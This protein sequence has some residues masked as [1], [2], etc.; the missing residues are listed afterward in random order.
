M[1]VLKGHRT[2]VALP[3]GQVFVNTCG[4]SALSRG[5]SGD[6]LTGLI[7][8]LLCQGAS[9]R[10]AACCGVFLH[11]RAGDLLSQQQTSYCVAPSAL[12]EQGFPP[13]FGELL[14]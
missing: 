12:I 1:L 10:D 5:G 3:D 6:V 14:V 7:A 4:G 13:A 8:S 2:V 11:A 9:A